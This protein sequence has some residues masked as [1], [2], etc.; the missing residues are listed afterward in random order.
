MPR[1]ARNEG[2]AGNFPCVARATPDTH[3]SSLPA[4]KRWAKFTPPLRR[5]G[6]AQPS[7]QLNLLPIRPKT[8]PVRSNLTPVRTYRKPVHA[9]RSPVRTGREAGTG[10]REGVRA[11]GQPRRF[12]LPP[13]L[14]RREANVPRGAA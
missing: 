14:V 7:I 6:C 3:R 9:Y 2:F 4:L 1:R 10:G 5:R 13:L 11:G 12:G 8:P